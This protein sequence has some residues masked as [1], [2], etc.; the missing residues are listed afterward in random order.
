MGIEAL[1][2]NGKVTTDS[3]DKAEALA[4]QYESI[5]QKEN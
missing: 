3:I 2:Y 4:N 5:F 1:N